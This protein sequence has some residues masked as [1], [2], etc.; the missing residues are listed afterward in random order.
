SEYFARHIYVTPS[1]P[2]RAE[3]E[4]RHEIGVGRLMFGV[5]YPHIESTWP[6]TFDWIRDAFADTSENEA[7]R[8]LGLNALEAYRLDAD[9]LAAVSARIG[10]WPGELFGQARGVDPKLLEHFHKRAGYL[11]PPD[12]IDEQRYESAIKEDLATL[13]P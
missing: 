5:D 8:I 6:N 10:P 12:P 9:A 4:M 3:I 7:R 13:L 1:S 11:R 2:H